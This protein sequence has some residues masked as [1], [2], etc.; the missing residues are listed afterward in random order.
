MGSRT[1]LRVVLWRKKAQFD[2]GTGTLDALAQAVSQ[3]LG[4]AAP[5]NRKSEG[6]LYERLLR[7]QFE[8]PDLILTNAGMWAAGRIA[9]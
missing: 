2:D 5:V 7:E 8:D 4:A 3:R 1:G 6:R 9:A